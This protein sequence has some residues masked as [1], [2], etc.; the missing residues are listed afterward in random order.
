MVTNLQNN[1]CIKT[2]KGS[3]TNMCRFPYLE[4]NAV[5]G[6][7]DPE[8]GQHPEPSEDVPQDSAQPREHL[9][10]GRISNHTW[11]ERDSCHIFMD[12]QSMDFASICRTLPARSKL[13]D[14]STYMKG[15]KIK[16]SPF[17]IK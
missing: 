14:S 8:D 17:G 6:L 4:P 10:L 16:R 15:L 5:D 7:A 3:K 2:I 11:G 9:R 1:V 13:S 12:D